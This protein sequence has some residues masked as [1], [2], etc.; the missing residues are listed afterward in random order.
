MEQ[1]DH[2]YNQ[3]LFRKLESEIIDSRILRDGTIVELVR[4]K[5]SGKECG[6]YFE[7]Q[8]PFEIQTSDM[9]LRKYETERDAR[10][11][12][13]DIKSFEEYREINSKR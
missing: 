9:A 4:N 8:T 7:I 11:D 12:L 6:V 5:I 3:D 13:S 10:T 1:T 2:K